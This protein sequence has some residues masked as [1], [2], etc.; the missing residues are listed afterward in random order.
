MTATTA[1]RAGLARATRRGEPPARHT[2][3]AVVRQGLHEQRRA[4]LYWGGALGV[5]GALMAAIWPSI[6]GSV[7]KLL[8]SYPEKLKTVFGITNLDS[9]AKYIDA[10]MLSLVVPG[11]I[12]FFA[13]RCAAGAIVGAEAG[14]RLD[15]IL[16]LPVSRR[17][18]AAGAFA[19]TAIMTAAILVVVWVLTCLGGFVAGASVPVGTLLAGYA[20]VWP[21]AMLYAGIALLACGIAHRPGPVYGAA[22]GA[23][24]AGYAIDIAGKLTDVVEPLRVVSPFRYYG[25]AITNGLDLSHVSGLALLGLLAA[26]AGAWLF[27]RRDVL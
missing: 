27:E 7:D 5:W 20:N 23:L 18:L 15:T 4:P 1:A 10:E 11:A 14:G 2:F 6:Q 25:S 19:V 12:V 13:V 21:L 24:L 16:A 8:D 9:L 17:V 26:L 22:F 3:V